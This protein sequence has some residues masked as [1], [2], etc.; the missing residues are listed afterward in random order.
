M[1][2]AQK[3]KDWHWNPVAK[4]WE[5]SGKAKGIVTA[6]ADGAGL[7][8]DKGIRTSQTGSLSKADAA[9]LVVGGGDIT[10]MKKYTGT[11][12]GIA[13][14]GTGA[15]TWGTLTNVGSGAIAVGDM[16][17]AIPKA[18]LD[19][20]IFF[21]ATRVPTTNVVNILVGNTKPDSAGSLAHTGVDIFVIR[22]S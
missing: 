21:G 8:S 2:E 19:G 12:P 16:V 17:L 13:A 3:P 1:A 10:K 6:F 15:C 9:T 5:L 4:R 22:S 11:L 18:S 14:I 20:N 7:G